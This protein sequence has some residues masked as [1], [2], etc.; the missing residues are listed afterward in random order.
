M[1]I[2]LS[3]TI[4]S[5]GLSAI[6]ET[7]LLNGTI[8]VEDRIKLLQR[9]NID[10]FIY[11]DFENNYDLSGDTVSGINYDFLTYYTYNNILSGSSIGKNKTYANLNYFN[12]KNHISS[13]NVVYGAG[14]L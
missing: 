14:A 6:N 4:N 3:A 11:Y 1:T 2:P 10:Q 8:G 12:L 7:T 13:D 5:I 9:D